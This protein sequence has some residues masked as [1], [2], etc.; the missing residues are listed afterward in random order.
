MRRAV[1]SLLLPLAVACGRAAPPEPFFGNWRVTSVS[2]PGVS[3]LSPQT[4]QGAVG[5]AAAFSGRRAS[6]GDD[7]CSG[8][9]YTRRW[10]SRTTFSEAY[11]IDPAQLS[12]SGQQIEFV[13]VTCESGALNQADTLIIRDDGT[14]LT[15]RDGAF[16]VLTRQ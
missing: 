11:G 8:P 7:R 10:L 15:A 2:T 5:T 1:L 16:Y 12:L 3:A 9:S 13:D 6:Y 14:M 4:A